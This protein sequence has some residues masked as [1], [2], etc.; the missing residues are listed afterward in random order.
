MCRNEEGD[1][2][3]GLSDWLASHCAALVLI[4]FDKS[5]VSTA[6][7]AQAPMPY[8]ASA[9]LHLPEGTKPA[10][11]AGHGHPSPL[12]LLQ[13]VFYKICLLQVYCLSQSTHQ[14]AKLCRK[15]KIWRVGAMVISLQKDKTYLTLIPLNKMAVL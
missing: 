10:I 4:P 6:F 12:S 13:F 11:I 3:F 15:E 5:A 8:A 7:Q 1:Q 2:Q 9:V 14:M